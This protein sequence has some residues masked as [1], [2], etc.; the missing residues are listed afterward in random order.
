METAIGAGSKDRVSS[1]RE[2]ILSRHHAGGGAVKENPRRKGDNA[3]TDYDTY[4]EGY[5]A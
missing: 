4:K 5:D 3:M 1:P 2:A